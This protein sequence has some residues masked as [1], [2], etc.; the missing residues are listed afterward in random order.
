MSEPETQSATGQQVEPGSSE[1]PFDQVVELVKE[2]A[3]ECRE[4]TLRY[5][6]TFMIFATI[7][8]ALLK[9]ALDKDA[10]PEL[11]NALSLFGLVFCA[12]GFLA[13]VFGH[14]V[15]RRVGQ[16]MDVINLE[17]RRFR[18]ESPLMPLR[19]AV[20]V[21]SSFVVFVLAG[22]TYLVFF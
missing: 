16:E 11:R 5:M 3:K 20:V 21:P 19:Y 15:N 18:R 17:L 7:N 6:Q 14:L 1:P 10:T 22:W 13:V 12:I 2:S 8:G 4:L 9:F